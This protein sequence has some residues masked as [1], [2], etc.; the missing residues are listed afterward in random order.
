MSGV[1]PGAAWK[2]THILYMGES[3][4][5]HTLAQKTAEGAVES[6]VSSV[7]E[8]TEPDVVQ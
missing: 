8:V 1:S 6:P 7:S 5:A 2:N 4:R 3:R